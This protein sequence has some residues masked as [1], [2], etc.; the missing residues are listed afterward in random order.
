MRDA[1]YLTT[2]EQPDE[3][4]MWSTPSPLRALHV[5]K[6]HK[7][8]VGLLDS[9]LVDSVSLASDLSCRL[10]TYAIQFMV[11]DSD[12]WHYVLFHHGS[13]VDAFSSSGEL[14]GECEIDKMSPEIAQLLSGGGLEQR[15]REVQQQ[16]ERDKPSE[17]RDIQQR[18]QQGT[19]TQEEMQQ[20]GQWIQAESQRFVDQVMPGMRQVLVRPSVPEAE[21]SG[22]LEKLRPIL[23]RD[24]ADSLVLA[25]LG[26]QAVCAEEVLGEF[27]KLVGVQSFFANLSYRYLEECTETDLLGADIDIVA[28]L[29]FR[30]DTIAS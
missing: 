29:K 4:A 30:T 16:M 28:H 24:A 18:I 9:D 26:K 8:W 10:E 5:S 15:M 23:P 17:I 2:D 19:A 11:N 6:A 7:G 13:Q 20:L 1:G 14:E 12:S 27:M 25:V 3:E 21:L 22:H